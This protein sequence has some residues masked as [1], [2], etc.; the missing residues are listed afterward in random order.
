MSTGLGITTKE[1]GPSERIAKTGIRQF[2]FKTSVP[3]ESRNWRIRHSSE[4]VT[5]S[6]MAT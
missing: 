6:L 3:C 2:S 4:S 5:M 1:K